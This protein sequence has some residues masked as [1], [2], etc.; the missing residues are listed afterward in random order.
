MFEAQRF[1]PARYSTFRFTSRSI[2]QDGRVTL[3]YA[4]DDEIEFVESFEIPLAADGGGVETERIRSLL[5]L[6]HWVAGVSYYK[7]CLPPRIEFD[8]EPPGPATARLL[9]VL[10]SEGLAELAVQNDLPALPRPT[11]ESRE[12]PRPA[13]EERAVGR[14]LVSVGGGKDSIVALEIVRASGLDLS[15]FSVGDSPAIEQ[16]VAVSGLPRLISRR[17]ID[18]RIPELNRQGAINGHVPITSIV[19]AVALLTAELNGFDA[20]VMANERSASAPNLTWRG[21]A[22]NHQFSKS[23]QAEVLMADA[24]AELDGPGI[25]SVLR[26]AS[27]LA[28]ARAFARMREYHTAFTSCNRQFLLD[29]AIRASSWC[30]E[31]NK[32]RFVFL[33]L[34]PFL[35]PPD[36]NRIFAAAMLDDAS[37]YEGFARLTGVGGHKPFE[38][39]GEIEESVAAIRLLGEDPE[40][41]RQTVVRRLSEEVLPLFETD[42]ADLDRIL[43]LRGGPAMPPGLISAVEEVLGT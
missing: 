39:V 42:G 17:R 11:F 33:I 22:V 4:L 7:T 15:L 16:T 10:F 28:V 40:W 35:P 19:S 13:P 1:D 27:E 20:V 12:T 3:G 21:V 18:T 31:C 5:S 14:V 26:P 29:P 2:D 38:C 37:Q 32:C 30:R 9:E 41:R 23:L 25:F 43:E 8:G 6:L 34:A 24:V 36:L